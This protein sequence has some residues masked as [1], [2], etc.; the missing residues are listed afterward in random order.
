MHFTMLF[1][2]AQEWLDQDH[3]FCW[4]SYNVHTC[5]QSVS[6]K[7]YNVSACYQSVL[8]SF[9]PA[10]LLKCLSSKCPIVCLQCS[11]A[12]GQQVHVHTKQGTYMIVCYQ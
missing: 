11:H 5:Y 4:D 10:I 2:A 9:T 6:L 1:H 12:C 7:A 8:K 3:V